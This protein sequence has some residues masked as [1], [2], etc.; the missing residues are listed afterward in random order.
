MGK[1]VWLASY[2]K[3]GNTWMRT[4]MHNLMRNPKEAY[5]INKITDLSTGDS[6]IS[7]YQPL[8]VKPWQEWTAQEIADVRWQAQRNIVAS[9]PDNIFVKTHNAMVEYL[10][11]PLIHMDWTAAAIYI[12]RN[13]LD[14]CIS[15][16]DHYGVT[17]DEAI[18]IMANKGTVTQGS[19]RVIYEIH[20]SWSNHTM[21]WT[22]Q[23]HPGLH[24]VRYEDM[25]HRPASAFRNVCNFLR[26]T[27]PKERLENAIQLSSFDSLK[28]QEANKGF[29]ERS[30]KSESFFRVGKS[31]Q[32]REVL[33]QEQVDRVIENHKEQMQRFRYWPL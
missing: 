13:P 20:T 33:S 10:G 26:L 29:R 1:I 25:L 22:Q 4:F 19:E 5:D 3:S 24:V 28:K 23:P 15:L 32:W 17:I 2:P 11:K 27:P 31:G 21:S 18:R 6:V 14:V 16:A 30:Q 12:V 9:Q 8:L 7:W